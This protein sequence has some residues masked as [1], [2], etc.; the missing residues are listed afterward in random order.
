MGQKYPTIT[1]NKKGHAVKK[2]FFNVA[3]VKAKQIMS[4][5]NFKLQNILQSS[6][7]QGN[8]KNSDIQNWAKITQSTPFH[9]FFVETS[10]I[11]RSVQ[12]FGENY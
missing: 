8:K 5:Q 1:D 12:I 9:P 2:H 6:Q 10:G 3:I 4:V 7:E 11:Q